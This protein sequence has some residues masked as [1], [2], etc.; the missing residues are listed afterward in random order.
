M[1]MFQDIRHG[2]RG[3]RRSPGFTI[4]AVA[5]LG[6][7]IGANTAVFSLINA[8]L[9][10]L[11]PV[12]DPQQLVV[13]TDPSESGMSVGYGPG[14]RTLLSMREFENLRDRTAVFSGMFA[15]QSATLRGNAAIDGQAPEEVRLR[16]V[17]GGYFAVLGTN[18]ILGRT[19]I[20]ADDGPP[21]SAPY[22][23]LSYQFWQRRFAGSPDV[24]GSRIRFAKADLRIIGVAP[25]YFLGE[26]VGDVPDFWAPLDMQPQIYPTNRGMLADDPGRLE[27]V[28]WLHV[29]GRLKPGVSRRQAQANVDVVFRQIVFEEFASLL[30]TDPDSLK[31]N[32]RLRDGSSGVS[33]MRGEFAEPLTVLMAMVGLVLVIACANI[34][35]LL[36][37]RAAGRQKEMG[38]R[39]AL[40]AGRARIIRQFLAESLLV[41]F[42]GAAA[43][44]LAAAWGVRA[45]TRMVESVPGTVLLDVRPD[46]RVLLF[47]AI[48]AF[49]AGALFGLAPA[50]QSTRLNVSRT[51]KEFGRGLTAGSSRIGLGKMLVVAQV[52]LSVMLLVGAGWFIRTLENLKNVNLGYPRER[53]IQ[54]RADF[55]AAGYSGK[56]LPLVYERVRD[57]LT[58]VP[59]VQAVSYSSAGLFT[60]SDSSDEITVEGYRPVRRE[61]KEASFDRVS[62]GYFSTVGIPVLLGREIGSRDVEGAERVCVVN[63]AFAKFYLANQNPIGKHVTDEFPDSPQ[64]FVIA[65]VT[66]N[67]RDHSLREDVSRRFYIPALQPLGPYRP[68]TNYEIRTLGDPARIVSAVQKQIIAFDPSIRLGKVQTLETQL[69]SVL[70][71]E[72]MVAQL[73]GVFGA[74]ALLLASL[75]LYGVLSYGVARRTNEIGIRMALGAERGRVSAMILRETAALTGAGLALGV[76]ASLVCARFVE[77]KLFGL[78]A[79]DPLTLAVAL[80]VLIAV[81]LAA[82]YL[83][84]RRASRVDPMVALRYE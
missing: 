66:R 78:R 42:L 64:T 84:A 55:A 47:T 34:A 82:G 13:L 9:L 35:N 68:G 75:G 37:A 5:T 18:P 30:Q 14:E 43:G 23:V 40:G 19:F 20:A 58:R 65:G 81:A 83:P 25:A 4:T 21:G 27:K 51:L 28:T 44:A 69:D 11:L 45:L 80:S 39:L 36:L 74:L 70:N 16:M 57:L 7:G 22:A 10:K 32:L 59:G 3:L 53:M 79:A 29:F 1:G 26:T 76:P 63:E 56:R 72:R 46:W 50:W 60:G 12:R 31:Q 33:A 71:G 6:L 54:V 73:S 67:A 24:L 41:S 8:V 38:V 61:D 17:S 49:G 15:S 62:P 77:N 52:A 48:I 2:A